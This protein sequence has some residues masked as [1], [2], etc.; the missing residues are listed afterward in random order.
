[1][2]PLSKHSEQP[3]YRQLA[4][5]L[6]EK[7]TLG[8]LK[9]GDQIMTE[10]ELSEFYQVSRITVRK[11]IELLVDQGVLVKR[12]GIGTFISE[13][14]IQRNMSGILGFTAN[15]EQMGKKSSSIL[16]AAELV[17]ASVV[18]IEHLKLRQNSSII[19]ILRLRLCDGVPGISEENR[20]PQEYAFLLAED[21]CGS[22]Y[23]LLAGRGIKIMSG[24]MDIDICS[25]TEKEAGLL[26]SEQ[27]KPMLLTKALVYDAD[28]IPVHYGKNIINM[29]RYKLTI[30]Q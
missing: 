12:P 29:D 4:N 28:G 23:S 2:K 16:L 7:I 3:L 6:E 26:E 13:R 15:C 5:M 30:I 27:G 24:K 19:R 14:K 10:A 22:L 17:P 18:D 20:F 8:E 9:P 25:L 11:G 21:L 1:M